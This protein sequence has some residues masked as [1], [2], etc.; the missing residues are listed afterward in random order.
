MYIHTCTEQGNHEDWRAWAGHP[1][2]L[3]QH[4]C[5]L[6]CS[7]QI[8]SSEAFAFWKERD[9]QRPSTSQPDAS[10][11]R[12][13]VTGHSGNK[14]RER[15]P[16]PPRPPPPTSSPSVAIS[17]GTLTRGNLM[18]SPCRLHVAQRAVGSSREP[19]CIV[20]ARSGF[21]AELGLCQTCCRHKRTLPAPAN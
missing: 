6:H 18:W 8:M 21:Q 10:S 17:T 5:T 14:T 19:S 20:Q 2:L 16:P 13:A 11:S 1:L 9:Q 15:S 4:K 3:T 12:P 7:R